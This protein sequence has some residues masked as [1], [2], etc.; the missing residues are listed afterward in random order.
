M[1]VQ[2]GTAKDSEAQVF[3]GVQGTNTGSRAMLV[4]SACVFLT[5]LTA[6]ILGSVYLGHSLHHRDSTGKQQTYTADFY[7]DGHHVVKETV[8]ITKR[9]D[10]FASPN[11]SVVKDYDT[12]FAVYKMDHLPGCYLTTFNISD[13]DNYSNNGQQQVSIEVTHTTKQRFSVTDIAVNRAV[14]GP[15]AAAMC[16]GRDLFI[17]RQQTGRCNVQVTVKGGP[18]V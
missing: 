1:K 12:G 9:E 7:Q 16:V 6:A 15:Q 10:V 11:N 8:V 13:R 5:L 17:L 18:N 2:M 14:L 3:K 4:G